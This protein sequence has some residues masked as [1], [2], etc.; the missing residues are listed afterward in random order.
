LPHSRI[1][2]KIGLLSKL[3]GGF[4]Q[5]NGYGFFYDTSNEKVLLDELGNLFPFIKHLM[6]RQGDLRISIRNEEVII[7]M[8]SNMHLLD[9]PEPSLH[10]SFK[11][12]TYNENIARQMNTLLFIVESFAKELSNKEIEDR[13]ELD[14]LKVAQKIKLGNQ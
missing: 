4:K 13:L 1:Q 14:S 6:E 7:F 2:S 3:F 11:N 12:K 10:R 5:H 9:D 8:E